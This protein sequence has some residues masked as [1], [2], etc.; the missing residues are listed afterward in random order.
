LEGRAAQEVLGHFDAANVH[1]KKGMEL[2]HLPSDLRREIENISKMRYF[3]QELA[4]FLKANRLP[5]MGTARPDG[6]VHFL[7]LYVK[8]VEDCP[9][10]ISTKNARTAG[11][12][13][14][15]LHL[16]LA[17]EPVGGDM[18]FKVTWTVLDKCGRTGD[19]FVIN[20]FCLNPQLA[21]SA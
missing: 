1:L 16:E 20:S 13:N 8:V 7:H 18:L 5:S 14:I 17:R 11:I 21:H 15:T 9:L 19:L 6:W 4:E 12:E 3:K 10:V 2:H